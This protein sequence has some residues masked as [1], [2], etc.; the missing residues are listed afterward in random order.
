MMRRRLLTHQSS[1]FVD[2]VLKDEVM[3]EQVIAFIDVGVVESRYSR[4]TREELEADPF[5]Y[6]VNKNYS[7]NMRYEYYLNGNKISEGV[8]TKDNIRLNL[9]TQPGEKVIRVFPKHYNFSFTQAQT[10]HVHQRIQKDLSNHEI[11]KYIDIRHW[12]GG[13][14]IHYVYGYE[15]NVQF[16]VGEPEQYSRN[17]V[18][19]LGYGYISGRHGDGQKFMDEYINFFGNIEQVDSRTINGG[20]IHIERMSRTEESDEAWNKTYTNASN[21]A[22]GGS[23]NKPLKNHLYQFSRSKKRSNY[24]EQRGFIYRGELNKIII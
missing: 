9:G 18:N 14:G 8:L 15:N 17:Y 5:V 7:Y 16:V 23:S 20:G 10:S 12:I 2:F 11:I 24:D 6:Q 13:L 21:V 22:W 3:G 19:I 4:Y 1:G